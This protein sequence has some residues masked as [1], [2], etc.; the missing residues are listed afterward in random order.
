MANRTLTCTSRRTALRAWDLSHQKPPIHKLTMIVPA[1]WLSSVRVP[2]R[3]W[4]PAG[5]QSPSRTYFLPTS[6]PAAIRHGRPGG[7][8]VILSNSSR[9]GRAGYLS[10]SLFSNAGVGGSVCPPIS[11]KKG[12]RAGIDFPENCVAA[13]TGQ[14]SGI[15][16]WLSFS[17]LGP[18]PSA[19]APL[20]SVIILAKEDMW[21]NVRKTSCKRTQTHLPENESNTLEKVLGLASAFLLGVGVGPS[22][23]VQKT[24]VP[25]EHLL[26]LLC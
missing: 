12:H 3:V 23:S 19:R 14:P 17:G 7:Y 26:I 21:V 25:A 16:C 9:Q 13:W 15:W 5:R 22:L 24:T 20:F 1:T 11:S 18:V 2:T 6:L 8:F 4:R 10:Y